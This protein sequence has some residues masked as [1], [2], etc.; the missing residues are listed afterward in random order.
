MAAGRP[1]IAGDLPDTGEVLR[2]DRNALLVPPDDAAAA[3]R[4]IGLVLT[5]QEAADRLSTAAVK[6]SERYTW[7]SRGK[8]IASF[9]RDKLS[10]L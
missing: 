3:A 5:S 7:A 10:D 2:A 4:A 1:I 6:D 9:L 8:R